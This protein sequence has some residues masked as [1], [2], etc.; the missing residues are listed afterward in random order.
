MGWVSLHAECKHVEAG[1][2]RETESLRVGPAEERVEGRVADKVVRER[3]AAFPSLEPAR[4]GTG[5]RVL[6]AHFLPG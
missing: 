3:R 5:Q 4:V 6:D 1:S 2:L